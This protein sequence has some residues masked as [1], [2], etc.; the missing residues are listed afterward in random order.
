VAN[1]V[2]QSDFNTKLKKVMSKEK[3]NDFRELFIH[4]LRDICSAESMLI[5]ALPEIANAAN[6]QKL[7][8]CLED[9]HR[10]TVRQ[11]SRLD[12]IAVIL[13]TDL[14]GETCEAM[15]GLIRENNDML[16]AEA[17]PNIRDAGLIAGAQRIEHY[18]IAAYGTLCA[19]ARDI[20]YDDVADM[21]EQTL[22]EEK[23]ADSKLNDIAL[24]HVNATMRQSK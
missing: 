14:D 20:G 9:H 12:E 15:K 7:Q 18:E 2:R 13:D 11:K 22:E 23:Q 6:N 16:R 21:L 5:D 19:F 8:A 3:F 10:E 1:Q 17:E 4:E 24:N